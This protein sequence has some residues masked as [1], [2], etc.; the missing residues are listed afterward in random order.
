MKFRNL[1]KEEV[2]VKIQSSKENGSVLVLYKDARA[3]MAILDETVGAMNW[4]KEHRGNICSLSIWCEKRNIWI[5]REDVGECL[6]HAGKTNAKGEASDAFKRAGFAWGIGRELYTAPFIWVNKKVDKY[7]KFEVTHIKIEDDVITELQVCNSKTGE[8][9]CRHGLEAFKGSKNHNNQID[10]KEQAKE[11]EKPKND[12]IIDLNK[13]R[14][15]K[16]KA[17][18]MVT[19][20]A[21]QEVID[22]Q[23]AYHK[24]DSLYD[25]N[26]SQLRMMWAYVSNSKNKKAQ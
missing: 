9:V 17:I 2:Q 12:K 24:L 25:A 22:K 21:T 3:D 19:D 8:V 10:D 13:K 14:E 16:L 20:V 23:L 15:E 18:K 5:T 7:D 1:R 11:I 26:E 6:D 4:K